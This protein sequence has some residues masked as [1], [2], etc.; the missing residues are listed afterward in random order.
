[1]IF[2]KKSLC[3]VVFYAFSAF[4]ALKMVFLVPKSFFYI[5]GFYKCPL[6]PIKKNNGAINFVSFHFSILRLFAF[7][8]THI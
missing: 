4:T 6:S 8:C 7:L 5:Y 2:V 3:N 1:M